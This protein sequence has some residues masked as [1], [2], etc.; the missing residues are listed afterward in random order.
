MSEQAARRDVL[1]R[2]RRCGLDLLLGL[3]DAEVEI[4]H[5]A[6]R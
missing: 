4:A 1:V 3:L 6:Q 2:G 5:G